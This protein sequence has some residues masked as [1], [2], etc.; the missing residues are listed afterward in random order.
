MDKFERKLV[1]VFNEENGLPE[2]VHERT[3]EVLAQIKRKADGQRRM[4]RTRWLPRAAVILLICITVTGSSV[5]ALEKYFG[6]FDFFKKD[7]IEISEELSEKVKTGVAEK[8]Q[9]KLASFEIKE[10]LYDKDSVSITVEVKAVEP[11]KYLLVPQDASDTDNLYYIGIESGETL[12]EYAKEKNRELLLIGSSFAYTEEL[13]MD[14]QS[15]DFQSQTED[16]AM[17]LV[18]GTRRS[19]TVSEENLNI[20]FKGSAMEADAK[21]AKDVYRCEIPFTLQEK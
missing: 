13:G 11:D 12:G 3:E 15:V 2:M 18:H 7:G 20:T 19:S 8:A 16:S 9:N 21:S 10:A 4:S 17:L 1:D 14:T 6:L 5:Y